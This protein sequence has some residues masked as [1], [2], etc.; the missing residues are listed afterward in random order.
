MGERYSPLVVRAT[1]PTLCD[2]VPADSAVDPNGVNVAITISSAVSA[3][4]IRLL[5]FDQAGVSSV[6]SVPG[7]GVV[8][9]L[10]T[11][12]P[13]YPDTLFV[14][15]KDGGLKVVAMTPASRLEALAEAALDS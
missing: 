14:L 12:A 2:Y 15:S 5:S 6:T 3:S 8:A 1:A 13:G 10:D 4:Q 7:L 11:G 9:Y